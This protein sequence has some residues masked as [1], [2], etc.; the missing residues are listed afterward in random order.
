MVWLI[1]NC[2]NSDNKE[3]FICI[4]ESFVIDKKNI[5]KLEL[6]ALKG[7]PKIAFKLYQYYDFIELDHTIGFYWLN[8][9]AE[10]G[11]PI[12]QYNLATELFEGSDLKNKTRAQ[13]WAKMAAQNGV[14]E[15][16][17]L[18][19]ELERKEKQ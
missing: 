14:R 11:H 4:N 16:I 17:E 2:N 9:A 7:S 15:A 3:S 6:E 19:K 12:A 1:M 8:I 5:H 13:F 10:N 18:L